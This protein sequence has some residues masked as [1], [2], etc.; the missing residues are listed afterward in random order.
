M[1]KEK[2]FAFYYTIIDKKIPYTYIGKPLNIEKE[3]FKE[4][5]EMNQ[6][7]LDKMA[8]IHALP[9]K[10]KTEIASLILQCLDQVDNYES[11]VIGLAYILN[12]FSKKT[13]KATLDVDRMIR[14]IDRRI[15]ELEG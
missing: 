11:K 10:Q 5:L 3:E 2:A 14:E 8:Y 6:D 15:E 9:Y 1:E 12:L 4:L 7:L 13:S